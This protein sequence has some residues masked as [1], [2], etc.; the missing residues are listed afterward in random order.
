[1]V[2]VAHA[3]ACAL[4]IIGQVLGHFFGQGR[5]QHTLLPGGAGVDFAN[6]IVDLPLH[7]SD[8]HD[9]VQQTRGADD[10]LHDLARAGAL[11]FAGGGGDVDDLVEPLGELVKV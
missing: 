4:Q 2:H 5:D 1:M 8:L 11:V 6:Q 10:L 7:G 3:D 9:G